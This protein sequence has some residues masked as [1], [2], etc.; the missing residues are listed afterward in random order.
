MN[1]ILSSRDSSL[2]KQISKKPFAETI[3]K[4]VYTLCSADKMFK[5][6]EV[7]DIKNKKSKFKHELMKKE[8]FIS[9]MVKM[10]DE[11]SKKLKTLDIENTSKIEDLIYKLGGSQ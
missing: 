9:E 8:K 11:I 2:S 7:H 1:I 5:L 4:Y 6:K 10:Q 3:I